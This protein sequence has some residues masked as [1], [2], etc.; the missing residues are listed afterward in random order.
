M[1]GIGTKLVLRTADA[2]RKIVNARQSYEEKIIERQVYEKD[3]WIAG[4]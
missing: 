3:G 1:S 2:V 4:N